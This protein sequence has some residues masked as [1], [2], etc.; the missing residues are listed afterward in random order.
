LNPLFSII[1]GPMKKQSFF[2]LSFF[3][4]AFL[5]SCK[6]PV[7]ACFSF[8]PQ[9]P[10][11]SDTV[12]F[13]ASCSENATEYRWSFGDGTVD[14]TTTA[15]VSHAFPSAGIYTVYLNVYPS[16]TSLRKSHTQMSRTLTVQ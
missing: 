1:F 3:S 15:T 13:D 12:T 10:A 14:T 9:H 7:N 5:F 6:K 11:L 8:S 2:L 16:P 4:V